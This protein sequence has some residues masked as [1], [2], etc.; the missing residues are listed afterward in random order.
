MR[1]NAPQCLLEVQRVTWA[2]PH[3]RARG[4]AL[5]SPLD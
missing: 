3:N 1:R 5:R 4:D 2:A